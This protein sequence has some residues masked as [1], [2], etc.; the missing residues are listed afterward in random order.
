MKPALKILQ[1]VNRIPYPL[2]DGGSIGIHYYTEGFLQAGVTLSMLAMNTSRHWVATRE[3]PPLY[4]QLH[5]FEAIDVDNRIKPL[6]S[7]LNLFRGTSY[8]VSYTHLTL[9]TICSV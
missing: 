4:Q 8:T 3:L 7:F 5:H 2:R 9:P 1:L 6:D